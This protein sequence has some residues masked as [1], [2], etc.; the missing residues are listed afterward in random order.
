MKNIL[1]VTAVVD[2]K[3]LVYE[4]VDVHVVL[5][6]DPGVAYVNM[7]YATSLGRRYYYVRVKPSLVTVEV[8][9]LTEE[10]A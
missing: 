6:P 4:C 7:M 8:L 5:E 10:T 3:P 1:K 9:K 2:G